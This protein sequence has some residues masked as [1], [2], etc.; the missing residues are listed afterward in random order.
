MP[1]ALNTGGEF[2]MDPRYMDTFLECLHIGS[3][4]LL[5]APTF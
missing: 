1:D 2:P 5:L 3:Y 4:F